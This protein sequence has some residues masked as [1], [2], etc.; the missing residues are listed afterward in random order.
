[1]AA[2]N[3]L[4]GVRVLDLSRVLAGPFC[5]QLL[6]DLGADVV[7]VERLG[8]GDDTRQ[9]GPPFMPG[10]GLSA[11]YVSCNRGKRSL[12]LDLTIPQ[13][14]AVLD[15]LLRTADVL[16]ENFLPGALEKFGLQPERVATIN[17]RLVR[18]SISGYG[19]T[20]PD[21]NTPGY[22]LAVQAAAGLM[23]ITG[24]PDGQPMKVGVAI[25]DVVT[26]LYAA[27][28]VL[29]GLWGR[30]QSGMEI[31]SEKQPS[32]RPSPV[33]GEGDIA[34]PPRQFDLSLADCTLAGLVNVVQG[35]LAT[36]ERPRRYGN[37]HPQIV[38]Y[39]AFATAD[40][41]MTL[42][43]GNDGQFQRFCAAVGRPDLAG[44]RRFVTNPA[45]VEH[46]ASLIPLLNLLLR[47]RT[48]REW[49]ELLSAKEIPHAAVE[50]IDQV[51][52]S[53]RVAARRMV[54]V[55]GEQDGQRCPVVSTPIHCDGE[56]F[57]SDRAPPQLGENS[58][59][60]LRDWL[61]YN[62]DRIASLAASGA[63][64]E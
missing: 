48:T 1:M 49:I 19:R 32:P 61:G 39:E 56:P 58:T 15:D 36:G 62:E 41:F 27:V 50:T 52:A 35:V 37:A 44:D 11:Y 54:Q 63:V 6:A 24:E 2:A 23:S 22:D 42:A 60:V 31:A 13:S 34:P 21:A 43:I 5:C 9:W 4:S 45:R 40:G 3:L 28:S 17:P 30:E 7:K 14:A 25:T 33:R 46:R 64:A 20:G 10:N 18:A 51:V 8:A 26:G 55:I 57:C 59:E 53:P 38:P 16:V 29:A 47:A 12:A